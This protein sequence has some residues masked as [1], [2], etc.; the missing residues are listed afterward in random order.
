MFYEV[1]H[2]INDLLMYGFNNDE[3][4]RVWEGVK[5]N[6]DFLNKGVMIRRFIS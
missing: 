1:D 4:M 2:S 3:V 6:H 5:I